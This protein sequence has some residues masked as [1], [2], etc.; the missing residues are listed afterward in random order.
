MLRFAIISYGVFVR[1]NNF[2]PLLVDFCSA[3]GYTVWKTLDDLKQFLWFLSSTKP[4]LNIIKLKIMNRSYNCIDECTKNIVQWNVWT[5]TW[6]QKKNLRDE[7][8]N[9]RMYTRPVVHWATRLNSQSSGNMIRSWWRQIWKKM[10]TK[11]ESRFSL[12]W[13]YRSKLG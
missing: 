4:Q 8:L 12:L 1:N 9:L 3:R 11:I 13:W 5:L 10:V 2:D 6:S 7:D